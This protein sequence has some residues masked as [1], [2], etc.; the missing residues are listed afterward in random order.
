MRMLSRDLGLSASHESLF[1]F[2]ASSELIGTALNARLELLTLAVSL[3][4]AHLII[5]RRN[6]FWAYFLL[7]MMCNFKLQSLPA[8]GLLMV[9]ELVRERDLRCLF[10]FVAALIF[11]FALPFAVRP[12]SFVVEC[13]G[14]W[15]HFLNGMV[16]ESWLSFQHVFRFYDKVTGLE[17]SWLWGRRLSAL[18]GVLAALW[19][20]RLSLGRLHPDRSQLAIWCVGLGGVYISAFSPASQ[21]AAYVLYVPVLALAFNLAQNASS[22]F[23]R[24]AYLIATYAGWALVSLSYS[25]LN[26]KAWRMKCFDVAL[27]APAVLA[28]GLALVALYAWELRRRGHIDA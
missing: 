6:L 1:Y 16:S 10:Y 13:Y 17:P 26:P 23:L 27:K 21:S 22:V 5:R 14:A 4:A 25:D 18:A 24:K 20:E 8:V 3:F 19:I 28:L 9:Y 12:A 7:A 15:L 2:L 11:W